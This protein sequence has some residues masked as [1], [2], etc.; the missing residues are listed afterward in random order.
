MRPWDL[1]TSSAQ[2]RKAMEDLIRAW[3]TV[4]ESWQDEVSAKFCDEFLEPLIPTA[5][6]SLDAVARMQEVVN[7]MQRDCES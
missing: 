7:R 3:E 4:S 6:R 2:M 1:D 5:K